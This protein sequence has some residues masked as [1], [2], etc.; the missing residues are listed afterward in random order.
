MKNIVLKETKITDDE[1]ESHINDD[2]W[3]SS[4]EAIRYGIA[5]D[6]AKTSSVLSFKGGIDNE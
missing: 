6:I 2:W 3:I 5:N 1:Y 4:D